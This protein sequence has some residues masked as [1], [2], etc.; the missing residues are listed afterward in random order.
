MST[1]SKIYDILQPPSSHS[2]LTPF[3]R[4]FIHTLFSRAFPFPYPEITLCDPS[5]LAS[6]TLQASSSWAIHA[7]TLCCKSSSSCFR[8][9]ANAS[10]FFFL[11]A[12]A[13]ALLASL[14]A[15]SSSSA[16]F[17]AS[18]ASAIF[19]ASL[20]SVS[21]QAFSASASLQ[22]LSASSALWASSSHCLCHSSFA[23]SRAISCLRM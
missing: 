3:L 11:L 7:A 6:D 20:A 15:L 21:L 23:F 9:A 12:S 10:A 17:H 16:L 4:Q 13:W 22:A 18:S 5:P 1:N 19:Q 14:Q 2:H 8:R